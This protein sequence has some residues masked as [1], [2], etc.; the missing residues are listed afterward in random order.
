MIRYIVEL[1]PVSKKNSQAILTNKA[2]GK[3]FIMPS[4]AYREYKEKAMWF[5]KPVPKEPIDYPVTV[6]CVFY[7]PTRRRVDKTNL[8]ESIHDILVDAGV[9]ADDNR[10]IIGSS[11]GTRVMYDKERPRTEIFIEPLQDYAQWG[12]K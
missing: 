9:L 3:P 2:T 4:K 8:E 6:K 5:L 12:K 10:D 7:M 1:P 11:D